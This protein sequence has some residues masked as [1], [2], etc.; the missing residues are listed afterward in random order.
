MTVIKSISLTDEHAEMVKRDGI[1]LSA[2]LRRALE[3]VHAYKTGELLE[4]TASL[5]KKIERISENLNKAMEF[6]NKKGL[7][8]DFLAQE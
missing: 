3:E 5:S 8:D 6:I 1:S 7:S 4:N 2:V